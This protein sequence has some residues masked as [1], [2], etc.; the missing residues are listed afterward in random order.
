MIASKLK[1]KYKSIIVEIEN[2]YI[3]LDLVKI[4]LK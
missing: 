1:K 4:R 3:Y 2:I